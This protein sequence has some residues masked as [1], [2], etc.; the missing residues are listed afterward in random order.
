MIPIRSIIFNIAF[1][2]WSLLTNVTYVVLWILPVSFMVFGQRLWGQVI[3]ALL[4]LAGI[5]VEY[6]GLEKLPD[7][8]HFIIAPKHQS[9]WDTMVFN[10]ILQHPA[11]VMKKELTYIPLYGQHCLKSRMIPVDRKGG[12]AALKA[13]INKAKA[14]IADGRPVL[15]YPQGTRVAPGAPSTDA[16]YQPGIAA[17]YRNLNVPVYPVALNSGLF[18]PRRKFTRL[19]G[20]IVLEILDPIPVGLT[21]KDFMAE[22]E[23]RTEDASTALFDEGKA[24]LAAVGITKL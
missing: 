21:R 14:A 1:Y 17:L 19:P 11:M 15:I 12:T 5:H 10:T 7:N 20:T 9:A 6:R 24:Q 18:W 13:M 16:P 4:P 3:N 2:L 22:L 8:N 23:R